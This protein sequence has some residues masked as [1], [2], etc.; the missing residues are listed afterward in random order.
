MALQPPM[1]QTWQRA[2]NFD[3]ILVTGLLLLLIAYGRGLG[4][5]WRQAGAGRGVGYGRALLFGAGW[6]TLVVALVS[7]LDA[8]GSA[9]LSAHMVQH[10]LLVLAAAPLLVYGAPPVAIG[11]SVPRSSQIARWWHRQTVLQSA[12]RALSRPGV[13]WAVNIGVLWIWHAP[14][15]YQAALLDEHIHSLEHAMFL[16]GALLFWWTALHVGRRRQAAFAVLFLFTTALVN[17]LLG[18][19]LTFSKEVW[20]PVYGVVPYGWGLTPLQDQQLAGVIMWFP[21]GLVYLLAV[22]LLLGSDL[23]ARARREGGGAVIVAPRRP[24]KAQS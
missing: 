20:Y 2:W 12:W 4:R 17:G 24:L 16:G 23:Q 10:L 14:P 13:A 5:L 22:L 9:L 19:L 3:P 8:L 11:W 18:V 21:G 7:P 15:L 1:P 6:L